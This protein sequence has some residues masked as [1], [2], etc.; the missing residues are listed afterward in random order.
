MADC[1]IADVYEPA[2]DEEIVRLV[3]R[4]R[5]GRGDA[6]AISMGRSFK[7]TAP[8]DWTKICVVNP[9]GPIKPIPFNGLNEFF[10][11]NMSNKEIEMIKD[12]NGDIPYNRIFEW[13]LPSFGSSVESFWAFVAA[14]MRSYMTHLMLQGWK[15]RW[16]DPDNGNIILAD[17]VVRMFGCQ[18][19][20]SIQGFPSVDD[21]WSTQCLL[22]AI[23]PL[24]ESMLHDAFTDMYRCLH[25][26][27]D[28]DKD[29]E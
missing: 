7:M 26:I 20:R 9:G 14:R 24:K 28:T 27:D 3:R 1:G 17:H 25:F 13:M 19:C 16:F 10:G 6:A 15:P 11:V 2:V 5:G 22:D 12:R 23:A 29:E 4:R 21:C 8:V 18:Q